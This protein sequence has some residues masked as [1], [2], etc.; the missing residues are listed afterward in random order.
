MSFD[1]ENHP[2]VGRTHDYTT[3]LAS[4]HAAEVMNLHEKQ[5]H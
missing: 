4:T 3:V 1:S 2:N 5:P